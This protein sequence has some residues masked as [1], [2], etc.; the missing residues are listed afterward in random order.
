MHNS[1]GIKETSQ[2]GY[3]HTRELRARGGV[4]D[5]LICT[6]LIMN[7][8]NVFPNLKFWF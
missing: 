4:G 7:D 5:L 8:V 6:C 1:G 3:F 2:T